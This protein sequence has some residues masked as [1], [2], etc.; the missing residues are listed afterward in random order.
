MA[1]YRGPNVVTNGLVLSLDA[2]N[3]KSYPG[4]GTAWNDL[5]GNGS[6][7]L[8]NGPT[9]NSAN[10]GSIVLD[11]V[12]DYFQSTYNTVYNFQYNSTFTIETFVYVNEN[13][14]YGYI[15]TNRAALDGSGTQYAGWGILNNVGIIQASVGGFSGGFDWRS[16]NTSVSTFN[17]SVY[18]KWCHIVWTNDGNQ[19]TGRMYVNGI[20]ATSQSYDDNTPPYIINYN[21][22]QK[23]T[24]GRS[25]ADGPGHYLNSRIAIA[26]IYNR[27][28]SAQ[29]VEQNYNATKARF[30][31]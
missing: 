13:S 25:D 21:G 29:E 15:I 10:A 26:R 18:Q 24:I 1:F 4:T 17:N 12:D 8:S 11:G 5:V 6:G 16:V 28:L 19:G 7:T 23:L 31:L 20:N 14:G 3:P 2:A 27:T 22:N 9:F 30:D